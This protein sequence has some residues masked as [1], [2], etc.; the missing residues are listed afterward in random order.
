MANN[1]EFVNKLLSIFKSRIN[2]ENN[3]PV[4]KLQ[5]DVPLKNNNSKDKPTSDF[6]KTSGL[7]DKFWQYWLTECHDTNKSFEKIQEVYKDMDYCYFNSTIYSRA[8]ELYANEVVQLDTQD[9]ILDSYSPDASIDKEIKELFDR[10]KIVDQLRPTA[11]GIVHK[12]NSCWIINPQKNKGIVDIT[13]KKI[14][15]LKLRLEFAPM[16]MEAK[17]LIDNAISD[18]VNNNIRLKQLLYN[19]EHFEDVNYLFKKYLIGYRVN[20]FILAPWNVLHFR[21]KVYDSVFDPFGMPLMINCIA[22]FRMYDTALTMHTLLRST[23][24]PKEH[25]ELN[26]PDSVHPTEMNEKMQ[27]FINEIENVG[28]AENQSTKQEFTPNT[29]IYT[30]KDKFSYELIE[31]RQNLDDIADVQLHKDNLILGTGVP[32]DQFDPEAGKFNASGLALTQQY[33]PFGRA[34]FSVQRSILEELTLMVKIHLAYKNIDP[35]SEFELSMPYPQSQENPEITR[36]KAD[37]LRFANDI[38]SSLKDNV[39]GDRNAKIPSDVAKKVYKMILPFT[40]E[41]IDEIVDD[42]IAVNKIQDDIPVEKKKIENIKSVYGRL[43]KESPQKA[44]NYVR[45]KLTS[46]QIKIYEYKQK[47]LENWGEGVNKNRHYVH[48]YA[49]EHSFNPSDILIEKDK[50][51]NSKLQEMTVKSFVDGLKEKGNKFKKIEDENKD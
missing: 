42:T 28:L 11:K 20:D 16:E 43:L 17:F 8:V 47:K 13:P 18:L 35:N 7:V 4:L 49:P 39:I 19:I 3:K 10:L 27:E 41:E 23:K 32:R 50:K 51:I 21:N 22:P 14:E 34:V 30:I 31:S 5:K 37:M 46:K 12:G 36:N 6:V 38:L 29:K 45:D 48:S 1:S 2:V 9:K 40:D 25:I 26:I 44:N 24:F 15:D 33:K